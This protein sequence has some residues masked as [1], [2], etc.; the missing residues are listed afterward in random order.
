MLQAI[1]RAGLLPFKYVV[2]DCL[3]GK[4]PDVLDAVDTCVGVTTFVAMPSET[5]CWLQRPRTEDKTD[6]SKGGARSKRVVVVPEHPPRTVATLA[7]NLP[8]SCWSQRKV[9]E[10]TKG[11]MV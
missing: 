6:I 7:A 1:V 8:A 3:Y 4:S 5:R 10:G 9:S 2:A 11:P